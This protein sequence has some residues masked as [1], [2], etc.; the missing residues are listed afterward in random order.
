[1]NR[2][3]RALE[4]STSMGTTSYRRFSSGKERP[5]TWRYEAG[6]DEKGNVLLPPRLG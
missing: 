5:T 2:I 1:M 4:R 3:E 6:I